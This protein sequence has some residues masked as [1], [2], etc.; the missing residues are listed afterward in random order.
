MRR[1]RDNRGSGWGGSGDVVEFAVL[2]AGTLNHFASDY[3]LP[4]DPG[5][6]LEVAASASSEPI[7]V[8]MVNGRVMV[9]TASVGA[10]FDFV[11]HRES[12]E[13][14]LGYFIWPV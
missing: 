14:Y 2:A 1:R 12:R 7:D 9:N 5:E 11:R 6:A 4:L 8:G 10:Y 3:G 13:R